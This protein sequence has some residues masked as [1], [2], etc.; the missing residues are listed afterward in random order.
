M[1]QLDFRNPTVLEATVECL[2]RQ[3]AELSASNAELIAALREY[4]GADMSGDREVRLHRAR[5]QAGAALARAG[6]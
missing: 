3:N 6:Q 2:S 5:K 4:I 1:T